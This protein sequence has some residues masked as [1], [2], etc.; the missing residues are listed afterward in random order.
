MRIVIDARMVASKNYGIGRYMYNLI[1]NLIPLASRDE[2]TLLVNDDFLR[3]LVGRAPNFELLNVNIKW[4]SLAEQFRLPRVLGRLRPDLFHAASFAVPLVQPCRTVATIYD[5]IHLVFPEHYTLLHRLYFRLVLP[6]ALRRAAKVITISRCSRGDLVSYYGLPE[7]K[8]AIVYP[9]VEEKFRPAGDRRALADF[10]RR[11]RL[12]DRFV[13]Y[14]G[15]RKRHKN[16]AGLLAAFA[17][18]GPEARSHRLVLSGRPDEATALLA[19]RYGI[20]DRLAY[21]PDVS[22][23]ELPLLYGAADVF[24]FPSLYEGFGLPPLEAL[25]CGTPTVVSNTSA[26]PEVV[27]AAALQADPCDPDGLAAAIGRVLSDGDL[28]RRLRELGPRRAAEFSWRKC[29]EETLA[30]YHGL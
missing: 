18:L 6:R 24:V 11:H 28:A 17:K 19:G 21:A 10:K 9:A 27:G 25:A 12:P 15:N 23:D 26:L 5:L 4:L 1:E 20:A 2:F 29:A 16:L 22:D 14:V 30:V 7:N 8:I 3:P 13:L